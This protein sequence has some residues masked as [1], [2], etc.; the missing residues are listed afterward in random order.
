MCWIHGFGKIP[1]LD[2]ECDG[3]PGS[4][5]ARAAGQCS[6]DLKAAE[7]SDSKTRQIKI[8]K[9]VLFF[10]FQEEAKK[11]EMCAGGKAY[12]Q[13]LFYFLVLL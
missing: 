5:A 12:T 4:S 2:P 9:P 13:V 11:G 8:W 10:V 3:W 6:K 1:R 7:Y